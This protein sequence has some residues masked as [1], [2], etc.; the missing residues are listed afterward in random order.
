MNTVS[1]V[2]AII[3]SICTLVSLTFGA[4]TLLTSRKKD[5]IDEGSVQASIQKDVSYIRET[6]GEI[7]HDIRSANEDIKDLDRRVT[8]AEAS[9]K[10]AHKRLDTME[11]KEEL[12]G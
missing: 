6:V 1:L 9:V 11:R 2:L 3:G 7:K 4:I 12:N 10:S 5:N 8:L